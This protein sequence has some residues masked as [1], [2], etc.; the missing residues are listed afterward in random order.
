M[1]HLFINFLGD[2]IIS[3]NQEYINLTLIFLCK[4][5]IINYIY[6]LFILNKDD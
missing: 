2:L 4:Y 5:L 1:I 3:L 6:K